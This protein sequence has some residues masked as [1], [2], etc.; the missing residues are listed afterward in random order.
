MEV[1]L[2]LSLLKDLKSDKEFIV[3]TSAG[4]ESR[5]TGWCGVGWVN[6]GPPKVDIPDQSQI[7]TRTGGRGWP[8]A[9]SRPRCLRLGR[10]QP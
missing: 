10:I 9:L 3:D 8:M 5:P 2:V 6:P 1:G 4:C 7:A